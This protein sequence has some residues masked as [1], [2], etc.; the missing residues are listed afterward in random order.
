MGDGMTTTGPECGGCSLRDALDAPAAMERREF[1][2]AAG[3]VI[4]SLGLFAGGARSA[5]AMMLPGVAAALPDRDGGR[6]EERRYAIPAADGV[7]ID[8]DNSIILARAAG[9]VY[10]FSLSCPHQNTALRW[11]ADDREFQCPKHKSHYRAD[12]TFI[13]GRA[14]RDMDRMAIRRDGNAVVVDIDMLYQQDEHP[15]EWGAAFVAV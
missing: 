13:E 1:L 7:A 2:R 11:S 6:R 5:A 10:A 3:L 12:G 14:T 15:K 8:K 4:A 9:R